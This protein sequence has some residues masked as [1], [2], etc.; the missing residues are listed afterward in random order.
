MTLEEQAI[1]WHIRQR[2][3]SAAEWDAFATWLE[4]SPAHA[5]AYDAVA[6][7]DALLVAP[8]HVEGRARR[9]RLSPRSK[10]PPR[11]TMPV[12]GAGG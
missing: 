11:T 3:M 8:E 5:R 10:L 7:A 1:D 6:M 9:P 12:G 4:D 2:D